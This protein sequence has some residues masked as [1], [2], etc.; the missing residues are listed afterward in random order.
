MNGERDGEEERER[1]T[2]CAECFSVCLYGKKKLLEEKEKAKH[3]FF[4]IIRKYAG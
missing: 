3:F 4:V 2:C 1:E